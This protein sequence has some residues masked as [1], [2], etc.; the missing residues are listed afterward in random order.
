VGV[1]L[2]PASVRRIHKA[3][4]LYRALQDEALEVEMGL[5]WARENNNP[6]LAGF[7]DVARATRVVSPPL[8]SPAP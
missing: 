3:G 1:S 7:L 4:V 2:V 5:I 8:D 6:V